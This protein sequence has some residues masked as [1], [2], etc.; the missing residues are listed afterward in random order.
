MATLFDVVTIGQQ[1]GFYSTV[2][3]FLLIF[4]FTYGL[5]SRF[6]PFGD[7]KTVNG[8]ISI[9]LGLIFISFT[10]TSAFLQNLL[11]FISAM[12]LILF[13]VVMIFMFM[14]V[15]GET[16]AEAMT[17]PSGYWTLIILVMLFVI[18]A[19]TNVFPEFQYVARP[20]LAPANFTQT[21]EEKVMAASLAVLFHPTIMA[22]V[23]LFFVLAVGTYVVMREKK[24]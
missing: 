19:I 16:I 4:A 22:T 3:P 1:L 5:L 8:I 24:S 12:L 11:P 15:K 9:V 21:P 10:K 7:S 17:D 13:F 20:E 6:K 18:I 2:L 23:L 14:G